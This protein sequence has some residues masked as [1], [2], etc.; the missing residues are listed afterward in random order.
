LVGKADL[1]NAIALNSTAFNLSRVVGPAL[2]GV[3]IAA[4]GSAV[5]FYLNSVSF[6]AVLIGLTRIQSDLAS[7]AEHPPRRAGLREGI[8]HILGSPWPKALVF[9]SAVLNVFGAS[10]TAILPV[11]ARDVLRAGAGGYGA[12]LSSFGF[13]AATGA[14]SIA[15]VGHRYRRERTAVTAGLSLGVTLLLLALVHQFVLA[16]LVLVFAGLSLASNAIMT[17][18]LLQTE[19]PDHLRGQVMGF[20]SFIVVGMA[21]F[22][23]LQAGWIAEH[24]GT[25]AAMALGG[26]ICLVVAAGIAWRMLRRR[27]TVPASV[28]QEEIA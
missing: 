26:S 1:M 22:G 2:A 17:N 20:Y 11:Y 21:P 24:F 18:T 5:C 12:L 27:P 15:A 19:A 13:G 7:T 25:G 10:F 14:I 28:G 9:L 23:S 4:F 8:A 16:I 3:L 6:V